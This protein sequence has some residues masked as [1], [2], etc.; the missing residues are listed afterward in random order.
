[1][2][3]DTVVTRSFLITGLTP[4][5]SKTYKWAYAKLVTGTAHLRYGGIYGQAVMAVFELP[6]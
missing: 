6:S 2:Q 3:E 5:A 4:G 1:V